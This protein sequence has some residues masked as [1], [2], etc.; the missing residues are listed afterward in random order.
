MPS[1]EPAFPVGTQIVNNQTEPAGYPG[2]S[3]RDYFAA[4]VIQS[5]IAKAPDTLRAAPGSPPLHEQLSESAY[6]WADAMLKA[7][8]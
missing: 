3:L 2:M 8:G 5:L 7:R 6:I 4:A 1:K